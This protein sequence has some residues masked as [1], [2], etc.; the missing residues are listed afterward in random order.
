MDQA[1]KVDREEGHAPEGGG[2]VTDEDVLSYEEHGFYVSPAI[3][4][5]FLLDRAEYG[6]ERFY[7]G[8]HDWPFPPL[9]YIYDG[10]SSEI[11]ERAHG[12][13]PQR[14]NGLRKNDYSSLQ[15]RELAD[16]VRFPALGQVAGL[17][18]RAKG[19]RLWHDQLIYKPNEVGGRIARVGWHTDRQYWQNCTSKRM[20]TAWVPFHDVD[21]TLGSLAFL[22]GSHKASEELFSSGPLDFFSGDLAS[23]E[24]WLKEV[25]LEMKVV[26]VSLRRGQVTFHHCMTIHGSGPNTSG[27]PRKSLSVHMQPF[28]NRYQE[29]PSDRDY[30]GND[31]DMI[32]RHIGNIADY[33]DERIFPVLW[34]E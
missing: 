19:I 30:H 27:E 28:D 7:R 16:L 8:D 26:T 11:W 21:A 18:S 15:V 20:L 25:G 23:Q 1:R 10:S 31:L 3:L 13:D 32:C 5:E 12:W 6:M 24:R 14:G 17:L 4:P 9:T 34:K 33:T 2:C 22:D 29:S